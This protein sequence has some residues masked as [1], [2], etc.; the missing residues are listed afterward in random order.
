MIGVIIQARTSSTRLP[1]KILKP[2]PINS[3]L[4]ILEQVIRR[5]KQSEKIEKIIVATTSLPED[6]PIVE[7]AKKENVDYFCGDLND[8][9]S[10]FYFAAKKF[11]L[12][13][14]SCTITTRTG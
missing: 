8:V 13:F 12:Y 10:R 7:I 9:L 3:K 2:L 4:T 14:Y 11:Q 1:R 6:N 5:V